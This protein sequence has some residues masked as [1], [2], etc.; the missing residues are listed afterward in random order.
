MRADRLLSLVLLLRHRGR[1]SAAALAREL[2]VSTRTVVRDVE[3]LSAAGVPVYAEQGRHGG[4]ALLPGWSTDLTGLT[5]AE[6]RALLVA[7]S[8]SPGP[9]LAAAMRKVVAA[10]PDAQRRAATA[11]AGRVLQRAA[12]LVRDA[13][14]PP[15]DV[16]GALQE[17][18]F[19]GRR[20]RL[21]YAARDAE[22]RWRTVDPLGLVD[23][24]GQWYL[25]A[26]HDGAD[27]T[28]RVS[29]VRAA[30]VLDEPAAPVGEVDLQRL[31]EQRRDRFRSG[32]GALPARVRLR[33]SR[34]AALPGPV[35]VDAESVDGEWCVL[36]VRFGDLAHAVAVLWALA[37]DAEAVGPPEL[38]AALAGRAAA[39]AGLHGA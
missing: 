4:Y 6:A 9:E 35:A 19:A 30:E 14:D 28:Y 24:G 3:A 12:G 20:L 22:A 34:R 23:A 33:A 26:T 32:L 7:G 37:P 10:L 31:W 25:L 17:A 21:L 1:M 2:E 16:L 27:R 8:R 5:H 13:P 38:R 29:R 15:P 39:V 36:D 11:A 18:V